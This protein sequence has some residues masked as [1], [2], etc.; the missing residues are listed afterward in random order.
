MFINACWHFHSPISSSKF[1]SLSGFE[2]AVRTS[3]CLSAPFRNTIQKV[4]FWLYKKILFYRHFYKKYDSYVKWWKSHKNSKRP[5]IKPA[6]YYSMINKDYTK[7]HVA[8][9]KKVL[10][11]SFY[12]EIKGKPKYCNVVFKYCLFDLR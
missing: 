6:C 4:S 1:I 3:G 9:L 7:A 5:K 12:L 2:S 11:V 10:W 8:L